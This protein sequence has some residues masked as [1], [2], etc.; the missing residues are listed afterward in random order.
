MFLDTVLNPVLDPLLSLGAFWTILIVSVVI[1]FITTIIY[2]YATDQPA[3]R[4]LKAEMKRK[5]KKMSALKDQPAK[6]MKLQKEV[7]RLNGKY[8]KSSFKSMLYTFLPILIFFGW[9]GANLAFMPILPNADFNITVHMENNIEGLLSVSLPEGLSLSDNLSK[10]INNSE[11]IFTGF[12]GPAGLY[13]I[14]FLHNE[15]GEEQFISVLIT[16]DQAYVEPEHLL[17]D[18]NVFSSIIVGQKKLLVFKNI[19]LLKD[20]PLVKN[21]NWF[22]SYF[23]FSIILSTVLRKAF[24]LA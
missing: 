12:S 11:V 5:Q 4:V 18:S 20:I 9:L 16:K 22:W 14:S 1:S 7:M 24:K 3:L 2:K 6:A 10:P 21:A 23:L 13:D 17:T 15:S 19:F 8:M